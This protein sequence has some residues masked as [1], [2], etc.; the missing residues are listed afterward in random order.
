MTAVLDRL[1]T[2]TWVADASATRARFRA[3]D[4][5][6]RTVVGSLP[7]WSAV[8]EVSADGVP[9]SVRAVLDLA[10]VA[11][12]SARRDTDLRGPRFFD[13]ER[14]AL[15]V[16]TADRARP[17][18][19]GL[20]RWSGTVAMRGASCPLDIVTEL[21]GF[22]GGCATVRAI[23][24]LDRRDVG[25]TVPRLLVGRTVGIEVDAVLCAPT[26]PGHPAAGGGVLNPH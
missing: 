10:G 1:A 25:I 9:L 6:R 18:G 22:A 13:V 21:A 5:L 15:L 17:A 16:V 12:G 20:W 11:T 8:V 24:T 14:D 23:A 26:P 19:P 2:G 3:R 4:V 7:V